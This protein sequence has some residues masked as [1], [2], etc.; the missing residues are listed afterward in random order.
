LNINKWFRVIKKELVTGTM[1]GISLGFVIFLYITLWQE[2]PTVAA[3]VGFSLI[4]IVLWA[5]FLGSII[6]IVLYKLKLDPAVVSS[7]LITT[8]V[9]VTGLIIYFIIAVNLLGL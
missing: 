6:P 2:I 4:A 5:N 3:V 1:L 8:V 9:D 7:P